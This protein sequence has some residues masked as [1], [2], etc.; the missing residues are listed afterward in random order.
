[1]RKTLLMLAFV[2]IIPGLM[3]TTSCS[4][5]KIKPDEVFD[6]QGGQE[7]LLRQRVPDVTSARDE[8]SRARAIEE[9]RLRQERLRRERENQPAVRSPSDYAHSYEGETDGNIYFSF[10]SATL[11]A[12]AQ[13]KL[14]QKAEW[15]RNSPGISVVIG[16]HCDE[17]GTNEYNMALGDR[18]A[19]SAKAFLV[20]MGISPS[21]MAAISYGE[22]RPAD[23]GH[24]EAAWARNRR[25]HFVSE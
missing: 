13:E 8:E 15:L 6:A 19:G 22:E 20:N 23:P 21:R 10:D 7:G 3:L 18:R 2:F 5:K 17:R 25:A 11:S 16:G 9:E 1:M 14:R 12:R 24:N 4:K